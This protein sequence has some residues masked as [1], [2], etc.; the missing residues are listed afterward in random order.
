MIELPNI[1]NILS[2]L[3]DRN[4][5]WR[6]TSN[7]AANLIESQAQQIAKLERENKELKDYIGEEQSHS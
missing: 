7:S 4:N 6:A 1:D 5:P 2:S 3:R